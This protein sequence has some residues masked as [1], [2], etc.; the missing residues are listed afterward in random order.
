MFYFFKGFEQKDGGI[1][2][3][4]RVFYID[5]KDVLDGD[6]DTQFLPDSKYSLVCSHLQLINKPAPRGLLTIHFGFIYKDIPLSGLTSYSDF[7]L[8]HT[9]QRS[10]VSADLE[11]IGVSFLETNITVETLKAYLNKVVREGGWQRYINKEAT[12]TE[13]DIVMAEIF[14]EIKNDFIYLYVI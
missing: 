1:S 9:N 11:Y 2:F 3:M 14:K 13:P 10:N 5:L 6:Y 7:P 12:W 8:E 4:T